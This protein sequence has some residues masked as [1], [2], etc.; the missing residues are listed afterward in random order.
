MKRKA[1]KKIPQKKNKINAIF[2]LS[3]RWMN[4]FLVNVNKTYIHR[5]IYT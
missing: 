2:F 5:N 3:L 1:H 4:F